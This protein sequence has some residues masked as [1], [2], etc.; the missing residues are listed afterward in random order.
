MK[1]LTVAAMALLAFPAFSADVERVTRGNL[2]IEGIPE[3]PQELQ[4]RMRRY[5][6]SRGAFFADWTPDGRVTVSTRFGNTNQLH[7]VDTP[8]GARR[9]F[10]FFDEPINGGDWSPT[11][12]R[13]GIVYLRDAGGNENFQLEYLDPAAGS[14]VRLTDGR[15]R[16]GSGVWSSDGTQYA[17]PWTVRTGV[18][19]DIYVDDPTD[20]MPPRMVYE[21]AETGWDV[22]D[23]APDGK[24]LLLGRFVSANESYLYIY[25]LA[26]GEKREIEA[27]RERAARGPAV[28]ARDGK[29]V[30][31]V[32]DL[33]GEFRTLRHVDLATGKVTPLTGHLAWDIDDIALS[34][35][36]RHLAYVVNEDGAN[37]LGIRDLGPGCGPPSTGLWSAST[38]LWSAVDRGVVLRARR[39]LSCE[40]VNRVIQ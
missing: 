39:H 17:F 11:G 16:A 33:G 26:T 28:F 30:Y 7:V 2:A 22:A 21:A 29:G 8:M 20:K 34:R 36:G 3:I 5:Q 37:R 31:Y 12:A 35:D 14:P 18:Q 25:D 4:Q 23:W 38:G 9:Q 32:S 19:T 6:F 1:R 15:G 27:S 40:C 10:T 24:S 13:K